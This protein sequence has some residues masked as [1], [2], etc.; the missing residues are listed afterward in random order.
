MKLQPQEVSKRSKQAFAAKDNW[1]TI[2][3][4][5]YQYAL[6][7]RN[8]YDGY[9]EGNVPGQNK[10]SRVFDSTAIHSV[11]RFANRIQSGLFPPY[12][13][14]CRLEP[15]NDIPEERRGEVQQ[16]L[17]LY[18]DK[19][20]SVLR[21]SNFDLA[22]GEFLLDL[23]V[24]TAAMLI[25]PGDDLNPI[26]YT[27]VPQYLIAIEEGPNGTVD[28]VYRK[29]KIPA[30]TIKRQFPDAKISSDLERLIQDKP[31][32]KIELLEAVLIDP[33]RKDY[34]YH[35]IHEKTKE[36]LVFRRM[37]QTPWVV[38]RYM[39]VPG[40][41][42]GRGPLVTA[43]PDIKTLNKTLELLLKNASLAISGV[44]TA[45]DDGVINPN[46]I[47]IQ[48]GA[49]I[50]VARNGG[51]QGASLAPLPRSGDFNVSQIVI[52]DLRMNIKKTLLDDTLPP[53]NMSARSA[54][55]IVERMKELAQNMGAAFG[56]LI[57]ETMVPIIRRT[58]QIMDEKGLIQL[59]LKVN[60]LEIKV[61]PI[62][63]LAKAQNL[64]EVNEVMQFFQ[65]ANALGPGGMAEI[66]PDAIAA[67]VGDKLGIAAKLRNTEEEKQQIQQEAIA[68]AQSQMM[69]PQQSPGQAASQAPPPEEPAMALEEEARA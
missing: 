64:D 13:K 27:P 62:S 31:Q 55:E 25:Q 16:A 26:S 53:D 37:D 66:K 45:A 30:D 63:P 4:E 44:Y 52:N 24:G 57:T 58:L 61:V 14:W 69:G 29:L 1:R 18:L 51:P 20:F 43:I 34:C 9:Y 15:G 48:P 22:I 11:Q 7:Q 49:I 33:Q 40:E 38:S 36:E 65:I 21:Q 17:D 19:L 54:T 5:C 3:E 67:F 46:S 35:I 28:N 10:M 32:E 23:S 47:K 50:P 6:P 59:P 42:M 60:G 41:V 56:R 39:K 2:Y 68:L 8:L 12:K